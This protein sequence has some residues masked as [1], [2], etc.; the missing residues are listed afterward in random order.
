MCMV[1]GILEVHILCK[2]YYI[3]IFVIFYSSRE[4]ISDIGRFLCLP[5][6]RLRISVTNDII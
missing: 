3:F 5:D 2:N 4:R 1:R 6:I